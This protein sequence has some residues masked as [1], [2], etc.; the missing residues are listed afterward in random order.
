MR[1]HESTSSE[2]FEICRE[3]SKDRHLVYCSDRT[4][5]NH[6]RPSHERYINRYIRISITLRFEWCSLDKN[7]WLGNPYVL[8]DRGREVRNWPWKIDTL[9]SAVS[10]RPMPCRYLL[11]T[12]YTCS[13]L[14]AK[15]R[16]DWHS[17]IKHKDCQVRIYYVPLRV[18]MRHFF[19]FRHWPL[20]IYI[21]STWYC[22]IRTAY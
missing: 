18:L 17:L 6:T 3:R 19:S 9:S 4:A 11:G 5:W 12:R 14:C 7:K 10:K 15:L 20:K 16:F 13:G 21:L 2:R 8:Q 1:I 22:I